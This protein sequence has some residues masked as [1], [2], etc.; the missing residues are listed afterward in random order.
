MTAVASHASYTQRVDSGTACPAIGAMRN[1][2]PGRMA[3]MNGLETILDTRTLLAAFHKTITTGVDMPDDM[4]RIL[5]GRMETDTHLRD[6]VLLMALLDVD[7][8]DATLTAEKPDEQY[9]HVA[10][11]LDRAWRTGENVVTGERLDWARAALTMLQ[12]VR[13]DAI[14]P[15]AILAYI[16]WY[17]GDDTTAVKL[18]DKVLE[19]DPDN[20]FM[21]LVRSNATHARRPEYLKDAR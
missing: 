19:Q 18:A 13:P 8:D 2:R 16:H 14:Q 12:H 11:L 9:D 20:M 5:A 1:D 3:W 17:T 15:T 10:A 7:V 6:A 4:T 21:R